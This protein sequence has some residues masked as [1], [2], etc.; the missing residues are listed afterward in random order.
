[1]IKQ[2][3]DF[4]L[5]LGSFYEWNQ[6]EILDQLYLTILDHFY[7]KGV[8]EGMAGGSNHEA[9]LSS[10]HTTRYLLPG[11]KGFLQE[12]EKL[13]LSTPTGYHPAILEKLV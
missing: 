5:H 8:I 7:Y 1:L 9:R 3:E 12:A 11:L 6:N 4:S 2:L 10:A 13:S